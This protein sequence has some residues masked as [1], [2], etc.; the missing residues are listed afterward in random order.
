M[1]ENV[2]AKPHPS[3]TPPSAFADR[4]SYKWWVTWTIMVGSFLFALDT[5]IVNI[6]IPKMQTALSASVDDVEWVVT[7]YTLVLGVVVP[8]TGWLGLR[9]GQTRLYIVSMLGFTLGSALCGFA[10]SLPSMIAFR[11]V[12]AIPGGRSRRPVTNATS[13]KVTKP[14]TSASAHWG[15]TRT[16]SSTKATR[17]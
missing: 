15:R 8:L 2:L 16:S 5:T 3:A 13:G 14:R 10:W 1:E 12:Q 6:A 9:I 17:S 7:G 4:P 11:V